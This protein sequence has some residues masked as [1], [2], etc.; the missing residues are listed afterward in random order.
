[1]NPYIFKVSLRPKTMTTMA[2]ALART[3]LNP[4]R[5]HWRVVRV[6]ASSRTEA[7]RAA[8]NLALKLEREQFGAQVRFDVETELVGG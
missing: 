7:A 8:K 1:M 6:Q 2:A 3:G 5:K 4:Y